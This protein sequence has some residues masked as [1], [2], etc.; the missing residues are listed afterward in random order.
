MAVIIKNIF[1]R[2]DIFLPFFRS[3]VQIYGFL[4]GVFLLIG[5]KIVVFLGEMWHYGSA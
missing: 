5:G 1:K 2:I 3:I 4:K